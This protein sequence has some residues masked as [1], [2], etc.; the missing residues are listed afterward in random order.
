MVICIVMGLVLISAV[1]FGIY[2]KH[3]AR[4]YI[5]WDAIYIALIQDVGVVYAKLL[6]GEAM[7]WQYFV[8]MFMV[9]SGIFVTNR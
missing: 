5:S 6:L 8:A 9:A 3:E 1:C 4:Y 2:N 7:K